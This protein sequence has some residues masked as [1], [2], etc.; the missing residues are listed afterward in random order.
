MKAAGFGWKLT[1]R[2]VSFAVLCAI[3]MQSPFVRAQSTLP[4]TVDR[5]TPGAHPFIGVSSSGVPQVNIVAPN[6]HG[7]SVNNFK[8]YSVGRAGAVLINSGVATQS[9]IAGWVQGNPL[10]GNGHAGVIV[11]QVRSGQPTQLLGTTEI[12][13][14]RANLIIANPAGISCAGCGFIGAP[15]VSLTTG[16]PSLNADGAVAG[17]DVSR[18]VIGIAG[19][20]L[21]ARGSA[22]DLIARA[23]TI[24]AQLWADRV[25]GVTGVNEVPYTTGDVVVREPSAS[26][27]AAPDVAIDVQAL[28]SMYANSVRLVGTEAG[29]GV[30]DAGSVNSLTGEIQISSRGEVTITPKGRL[31]S[32]GPTHIDA[33]AI[34]NQGATF[35]GGKVQL[36]ASGA[37]TSSGSVVAAG[38]LSVNAGRLMNSGSLVAGANAS[39][40]LATPADL[41]LSADEI[42]SKG[43]L[44]A[45]GNVGVEGR[46]VKLNDGK[47]IAQGDIDLDVADTLS[48][49]H[50]EMAGRNIRVRTA[51]DF[52]HDDATLKSEG[53]VHIKARTLSNQRGSLGAQSLDIDTTGAFD[54]RGGVVDG[55][56]DAH[57]AAASVANELGRIG[58][59]NGQLTVVASD[60]LEN[61]GGEIVG[62]NGLEIHAASI[63]NS[64]G[65]IGT[66]AGNAA[67]GVIA[68]LDNDGGTLLSADAL[69]LTLGELSN[70][71]GQIG[72]RS[73]S[74]QLFDGALDNADG[75]IDVARHAEIHAGKIV[76]DRAHLT[77]GDGLSISGSK[78]SNVDGELG[79]RS[80]DTAVKL[81]GALDN[82]GGLISSSDAELKLTAMGIDNSSN[83]RLTGR[84]VE[85]DAGAET[86][87]NAKG[88]VIASQRIH[89]N[90]SELNNQE[91]MVI[92]NAPQHGDGIRIDS[93]HLDNRDGYISSSAAFHAN[94]A[95]LVND[96]GA[97]F[98]EGA[99]RV[100]STGDIT[101]RG[102]QLG[103]NADVTLKATT[104]D[105][106][107]GAMHAGGK[108]STDSNVILNKQTKGQ[109]ASSVD[110]DA[111][112]P[113]GIEGA[114]VDLHARQRI[115][116]SAGSIRADGMLSL[117]APQMGN[118]EGQIQSKGRVHVD[119]GDLKNDDGYLNGD[120]ELRVKADAMTG[121]GELESMHDVHV[122]LGSDFTNTGSIR[123]G[124]NLDFTSS[125][126]LENHGELSSKNK[127]TVK[128][129][130]INNRA[131]GQIL[132]DGSVSVDGRRSLLNEGL[133]DGGAT[134]VSSDDGVVNRGRIYGDSI[135]IKSK[136]L[137]N[138]DDTAGNGGVIASRGN[139]DI[140][141]SAMVNRG[142]A[143]TY[144]EN[145]IRIGKTLDADQR[146]SG[147]ADTVLNSGAEINAGHDIRI[148]AKRLDNLNPDFKTRSS[149]VDSGRQIWH[150]LNGSTERLDPSDVFLY[151]VNNHQWRRGNDYHWALDDADDYKALLLPSTKYLISEVARFTKNGVVGEMKRPID[152]ETRT[153]NG[154]FGDYRIYNFLPDDPIWDYFGLERP[155]SLPEGVPLE[156][157]TG[158][159]QLACKPIQSWMKATE[160][161]YEGLAQ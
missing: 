21:D 18:G 37:V 91:G 142:H 107:L 36:K 156:F 8:Q 79:A 155:A 29:V 35:G 122:E 82:R 64:A 40:E 124:G 13:G 139:L 19:E 77:A 16:L 41:R 85:I 63:S 69:T 76:N 9:R 7:V 24:N 62:G 118:H 78:L 89:I 145:D 60:G 135:A 6:Q 100:D 65:S 80:G 134:V 108:L 34:D 46:S 30:R 86:L 32:A 96:A 115:D 58:S 148:A 161:T 88:K 157:C 50:G 126:I 121:G 81:S 70:H 119:A 125:G 47:I 1:M 54:N 101:N 133:I 103:S 120:E 27:E 154:V 132:G 97:V 98:S 137:I 116:N 112:T 130:V 71:R 131:E 129:E 61:A 136:Q 160:K 159:T 143:L 57:I 14:H 84:I 49:M 138:E 114:S 113:P 111:M 55:S 93:G 20:G 87:R 99:F 4:I 92:T 104:I 59:S 11:N 45:G 90:S 150:Q 22:I 106:D 127:T 158:S 110:G 10:L 28:G 74:A 2:P 68:K 73:M 51:G 66:K 3:G 17:F 146:A 94:V 151:Q 149:T 39:G 109:T 144:A 52:I 140:G 43:T 53:R 123:A 117:D 83:G 147:T 95:S 23:M 153:V 48:D 25:D 141:S 12:A 26:P 75:T 102:G 38:A 42:I 5:S 33:A 15:R 56:D 67:V 128:A 44:S 152:F 31:Q 72:S 105:N